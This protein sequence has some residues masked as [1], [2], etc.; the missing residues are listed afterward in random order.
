M[1]T[2]AKRAPQKTNTSELRDWLKAVRLLEQIRH[3]RVLNVID[4]AVIKARAPNT[5]LRTLAA[6][7][8]GVRESFE[9]L[10]PVTKGR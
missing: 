2:K 8:K 6:L 9:R 3:K 10:R 5:G 4:E 1:K 7:T